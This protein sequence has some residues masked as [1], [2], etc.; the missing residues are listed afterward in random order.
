MELQLIIYWAHS[1]KMGNHVNVNAKHENTS[2]LDN[3]TQRHLL[4]KHEK[5]VC[6]SIQHLLDPVLSGNARP[7]SGPCLFLP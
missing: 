7:Q 5:G 6:L 1:C 4:N 3:Q 2:Y